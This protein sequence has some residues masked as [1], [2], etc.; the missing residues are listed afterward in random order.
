M[1]IGRQ[2]FSP[3]SEA[4][5][6]MFKELSLDQDAER[7]LRE[8][9]GYGE[10]YYRLLGAKNICSL[11]ASPYEGA[12]H[13]HDMNKPIDDAL[14]NR[15]SVVHDGG[16][17]EHVF[18]FPQAIK[19]CMEMVRIGGFFL[20]VSITNNFMGHGFYQFSPDL[21][22]R[23]F[24]EENGF[25]VIAVLLHEV[26][27]GGKWYKVA[28]T[29]TIDRCVALH[30]PHPTYILTVAKRVAQVPIFATSPQQSHYVAVWEDAACDSTEA[31]NPFYTGAAAGF[32]KCIP[33]S[34]KRL[35]KKLLTRSR[36]NAIVRS[37]WYQQIDEKDVLRGKW[38]P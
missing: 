17:I 24:S 21:I 6:R 2:S 1:M 18:D 35:A 5:E 34:W 19:N 4:L 26:V 7:F 3:D 23:T 25:L 15:F 33:A 11:D 8:S 31:S 16:T 12:T 28:D 22:Y 13:I 29:T 32:R 14:K 36:Q 27:R 9:G 10:P 20:Q 30:N 38:N 37:D